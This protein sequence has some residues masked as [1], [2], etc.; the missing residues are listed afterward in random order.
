MPDNSEKPIAFAS[1]TLTPA[2]NN[3]SQLEKEALAIIYTVKCFQQYLH[4]T[5]FKLYSDHKLLERLLGGFLAISFIGH[6]KNPMLG[7]YS[8][9]ISVHY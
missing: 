1:R 5:H 9:S 4:G 8:C 3:Y 7:T 2:E 6:S